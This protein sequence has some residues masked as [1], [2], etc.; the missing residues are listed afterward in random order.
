MSYN[1]TPF[2]AL[3]DHIDSITLT[4]PLPLSDTPPDTFILFAELCGSVI[5]SGR[6]RPNLLNI[7]KERPNALTLWTLYCLYYK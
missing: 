3:I 7:S 4:G 5:N 6:I 1:V 2:G